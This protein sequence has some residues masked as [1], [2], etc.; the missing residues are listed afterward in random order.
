MDWAKGSGLN[1]KVR[2]GRMRGVC[3]RGLREGEGGGE[4]NERRREEVQSKAIQ[5]QA[6][7]REQCCT[8]A[9]TMHKSVFVDTGQGLFIGGIA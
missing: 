3:E 5:R 2:V 1:G 9:G 7:P 6:I 4:S 8:D